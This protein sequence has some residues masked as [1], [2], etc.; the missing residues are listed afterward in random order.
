LRIHLLAEDRGALEQIEDG[1]RQA[2]KRRPD[3]VPQLRRG[4][5]RAAAAQ[6]ARDRPQIQRVAAAAAVSGPNLG[7]RGPEGGEIAPY[8]V[9][10][11]RC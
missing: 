4:V 10:G 9:R 2:P 1:R 5:V 3:Q 11:E 7:R 6:R 8:V